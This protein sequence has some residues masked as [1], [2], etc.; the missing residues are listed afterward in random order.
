MMRQMQGQVR[1]ELSCTMS[2]IISGLYAITP[3]CADTESLLVMTKKALAGGAKVIQ[4]R[5]KIADAM[6]RRKQAGELAS[7]CRDY[8]VPFI[9]NDHLDLMLEINADGLHLGRNDISVSDARTT[10][11]NNKIIGASCYNQINLAVHAED[12]GADYV[13][14]GAFFTSITKP[15]AVVAPLGILVSAKQKLRTPVVAIG[16]IT[17][18][19]A[20]MLIARG[21]DAIAVS[22]ALFGARD[23][24][25]MA[26]SFS[27]LFS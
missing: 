19:N 21:G 2:S 13:A 11:G 6:L 17:R 26:K 1:L 22:N 15:D 14:F 9:I 12:Q 27:Q 8:N 10:L 3:D 18:L 23:I 5:N 4:Y 20:T 16:G 7:L 25:V 24:Q